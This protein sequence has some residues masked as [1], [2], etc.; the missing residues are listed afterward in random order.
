LELTEK[1]G[2]KLSFALPTEAQWEF[3]ARGGVTNNSL[4]SVTANWGIGTL[5]SIAW[6]K[7][8]ILKTQD[9]PENAGYDSEQTVAVGRLAPNGFGL[10][11]V[12]G[13]VFEFCS[14]FSSDKTYSWP[15]GVADN[16]TG[17]AE[18]DAAKTT[19][20]IA[21]HIIRGGSITQGRTDC[22]LRSRFS[23]GAY[24]QNASYGFRV[25]CTVN[26]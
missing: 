23:A 2:N 8:N 15:E 13:N 17:V 24:T 1:T 12:L 10:Y 9:T 6:S 14:D 11:D 5:R 7:E 25:I 19:N 3:A 18:K 21:K 20:G 4:Y 16:P 22:T 26:E